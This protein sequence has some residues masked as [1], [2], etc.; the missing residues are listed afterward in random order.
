MV[1][2]GAARTRLYAHAQMPRSNAVDPDRQLAA[3]PYQ[4]RDRPRAVRQHPGMTVSEPP[5]EQPPED[6]T[7]LLGHRPQSLL[8]GAR[9]GG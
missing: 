8:G 4:D 5:G 7:A 3:I 1:Y 6:D 2:P 9:P